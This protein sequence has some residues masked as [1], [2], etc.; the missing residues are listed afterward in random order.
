MAFLKPAQFNGN[1]QGDDD[2]RGVMPW[3]GHSVP[4]LSPGRTGFDPRPVHVRFV[5]VQLELNTLSAPVSIVTLMLTIHPIIYPRCSIILAFEG[6]IN[7]LNPELNP[8]CYLLALLGA[9]HFLHVSTIVVKLL[10]LTR[11]MSYIYGAPIPD[12]SRSHTMM[13]HSR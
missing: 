7:P 11:L 3:S 12:I 10:T 8:I 6:I 1:M 2:K 9:H 5:M 4:S 13:Q